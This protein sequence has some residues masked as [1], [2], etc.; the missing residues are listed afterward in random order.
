MRSRIRKINRTLLEMETGILFLGIS[1]QLIGMWFVKS[2][3][4]YSL[5]LWIGVILAVLAVFHMYRVLDR[6]MDAGTNAAKTVTKGAFLR[7][8]AVLFVLA[9]E[10]RFTDLNPLVSFLG[11]MTLKVA[12]YLQPLTHKF[13][14]R[15]FCETDPIPE[16]LPEDAAEENRAE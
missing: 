4:L 6:A 11:I 16:A 5:S 3:P 10:V 8:V 9:F 15:I 1:I 14:N 13:Y 7:Y 2:K 12:A